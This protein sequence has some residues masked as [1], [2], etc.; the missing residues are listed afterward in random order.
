MSPLRGGVVAVAGAGGGAGTAVA[1]RLARAGAALSL[2]DTSLE[3]A[4]EAAAAVRAVPG[5]AEARVVDLLDADAATAWAADLLARHGRVD[6]LVHLVGGWRGGKPLVDPVALADWDAL[7]PPLV[8]TVQ[9]TS[10]AFSDALRAAPAGRFVLISS[11]EATRPS[12]T[13][14]AYAAAKAAAETWTLALADS[15]AGSAAAATVVVVKALLTPQL[16]AAKPDAAFAGYTTVEDL[17]DRI[18]D[19]WDAPAGQVNGARVWLTEQP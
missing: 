8:R 14:A 5:T 17:A 11:K 12:Q 13:N 15:F 1:V 10:Q 16:R 19:L 18:S 4:E 9:R 7:E 3:R 2:V 6:G